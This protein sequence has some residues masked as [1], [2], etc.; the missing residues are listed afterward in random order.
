[1]IADRQRSDCST[2]EVTVLKVGLTGGIAAG[3][4][5]VIEMFAALGARIIRAD[6]IA[7]ELMLPG[8]P[9][10]EEVVSHFGPEILN[11]D[12]T[13][14][15]A[16]LAEAAFGERNSE[17]GNSRIEELNR[18]VHPAVIT[19]QEQ[20]MEEQGRKDPEAIAMVEAALILEAGA[21]ERFDRIVVVTCRGEQ[22]AERWAHRLKIDIESACKEVERRM[23]AQLPDE[24]KTKRA[25]Y[26]IDNSGSLEDTSKQVGTIYQKLRKESQSIGKLPRIVAD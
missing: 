5:V 15:R 22:R 13:V 9:V 7:H 4:S 20:W 14:N 3:K 10:Y 23:A 21:W 25:D 16:R 24:E 1:V 6:D 2:F 8:R 11:A 18:I 12:E 19:R 26:V 17:S